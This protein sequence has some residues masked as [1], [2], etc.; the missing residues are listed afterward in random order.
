MVHCKSTGCSCKRTHYPHGGLH[1]S[2]TLVLRDT[3]PSKDRDLYSGKTP[4]HMTLKKLKTHVAP[5]RKQVISRKFEELVLCIC[6][7]QN[8]LTH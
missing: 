7:T 6:S 8:D 3:E 1:P 5:N 2:I 4:I